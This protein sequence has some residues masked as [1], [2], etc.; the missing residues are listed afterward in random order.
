KWQMNGVLWEC[1]D[2]RVRLVATDG[3]RL[4]L[5]EGPAIPHGG[6]GPGHT[7]VVPSKAMGLLERNLQVD[8]DQQV[9]VS[10]RQN[11]AMF[12]TEVATIDTRLVEGRYPNYREVFPKKALV[13]V[14]LA[15]GPFLAAVRQSAIMADEDTKR[16]VFHF[17]KGKLTLEARGG[18]AGGRS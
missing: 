16:V 2:D 8:D 11:E 13:K 10:I 12:R 18:S 7:P 9:A 1:K 17:A 14:P 15:V 4:A 6:H 3:R 5:T